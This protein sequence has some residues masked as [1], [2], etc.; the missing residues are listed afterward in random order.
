MVCGIAP[1]PRSHSVVT[2]D[3]V[4]DDHA[5][6]PELLV[7]GGP[8]H[9]HGLTTHRSRQAAVD[10]AREDGETHIEPGAADEPGLRA[11]LRD[12]REG[13]GTTAA[14]FDTRLDKSPW[15]TGVASRGIAKRLARLGYDVVGSESFLVE[16]SEG[17]LADRE[18]DRARE[19]GRKLADLV[20]AGAAP[21]AAR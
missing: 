4:G 1:V 14:S 9:M 18:L 2:P 15:L 7:V 17:P 5:E 3:G 21:R 8:T 12:L 11:S 20:A 16:D 10:R 19:W 6:P 13:E